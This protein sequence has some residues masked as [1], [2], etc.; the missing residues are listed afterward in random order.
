M[1]ISEKIKGGATHC[2]KGLV[3]RFLQLF[4]LSKCFLLNP[5]KKLAQIRA[6]LFEKNLKTAHL[7]RTPIPKNDVTEWKSTLK[8]SKGQ[9]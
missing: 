7:R 1:K 5:G 3:Q 9:F 4:V 8:T 2:F 6:V